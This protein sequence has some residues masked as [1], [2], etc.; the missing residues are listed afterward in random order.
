MFPVRIQ[1]KTDY[2]PPGQVCSENVI[3]Q[4]RSNFVSTHGIH[5]YSQSSKDS[6]SGTPYDVLEKSFDSCGWEDLLMLR[7]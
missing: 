6:K 3:S 5:H 2:K 7:A 1:A 4:F